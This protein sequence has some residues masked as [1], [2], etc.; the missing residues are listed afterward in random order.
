MDTR[1]LWEDAVFE[2]LQYF[3]HQKRAESVRLNRLIEAETRK[4]SF[5]SG[6]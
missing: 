4:I 6:F 1:V 2:S 5:K 3:C